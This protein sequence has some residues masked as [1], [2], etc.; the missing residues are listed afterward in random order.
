MTYGKDVTS[1]KL[2]KHW[3]SHYSC[4]VIDKELA[5]RI[6]KLINKMFHK[7]YGEALL[8][9]VYDLSKH[10]SLNS[11]KFASMLFKFRVNNY[12]NISLRHRVAF[13][14]S[15]LT[16]NIGEFEVFAICY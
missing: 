2:L 14:T 3:V 6:I 13:E 10:L 9:S 12:K 7:I 4:H 11:S 16:I 15:L 1:M 5:N 8:Y